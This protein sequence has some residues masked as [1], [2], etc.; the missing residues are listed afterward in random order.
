MKPTSRI[1]DK[2]KE[3]PACNDKQPELLPQ[4]ARAERSPKLPELELLEKENEELHAALLEERKR[5]EEYLNRL[6]YLQADFENLSKR[7]QSEIEI[8]VKMANERVIENLL[9]ILDELD[10]ALKTGK[11]SA[12]DAG[13][14]A[15]IEMVRKKLWN[16]LSSEGL[17]EIETTDKFDPNL[18]EVVTRIPTDQKAEGSILEEIRKGFTFK[19]KVI[20]PSMVKI[21]VSPA[22]AQQQSDEQ[23]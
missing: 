23:R 14:L 17:A 9:P 3:F 22:R 19:G 5:A 4:S 8:K 20:R 16:I 6:K 10:L 2:P 21:A 11:D 12:Q 1:V 13:I 7:M 15:G 18:H